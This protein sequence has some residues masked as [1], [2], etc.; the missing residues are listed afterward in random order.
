MCTEFFYTNQIPAPPRPI[1]Q[2]RFTRWGKNLRYSAMQ[3]GMDGLYFEDFVTGRKE[4]W[5]PNNKTRSSHEIAAYRLAAMRAGR[6]AAIERKTAHERAAKTVRD[7]WGKLCESGCSEYLKRKQVGAFGVK[8]GMGCVAV[9]L[10]DISGNLWNVQFVYENG[11]KRFFKGARK[12][13][14]CHIIGELKS[15]SLAYLCEG[16]ATAASVH[17]A[18]GAPVIVAFDAGNIEPV[19]HT[20]RS[21]KSFV[22]IVIAADNDQWGD[23]NTGKIKAESAAAKY[24]GKVILPDLLD[25]IKKGKPTDFND[26]HVFAG[27]DELRRQLKGGK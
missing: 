19:L 2:N 18:T 16:Y 8:Y 21:E 23:T 25:T 4:V 11:T 6:R 22:N 3:L 5:F 20:I 24:G 13:G 26:L 9:P 10:R 14:L 17:M 15:G 12:R 7:L 27:I 1:V